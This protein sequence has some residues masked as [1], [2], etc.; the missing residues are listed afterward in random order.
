[1]FSP[2]AVR[3]A[4][5]KRGLVS[6]SAPPVRAAMVNSRI[7]LVKTLPRLASVAAFLCLI[8]AHFE[9]PD[10][11]K[12]SIG[13]VAGTAFNSCHDSLAAAPK[14]G[15]RR[16]YFRIVTASSLSLGQARRTMQSDKPKSEFR[17]KSAAQLPL[18]LGVTAL[19]AASVSAQNIK[20]QIDA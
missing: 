17:M 1:M 15:N 7:I 20:W 12:P 18:V 16:H 4:V 8:V 5:R 9:C 2:L 19:A 11:A 14:S 6:G 13:S 10:M 3:M